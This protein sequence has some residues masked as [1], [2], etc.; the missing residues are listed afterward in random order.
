MREILENRDKQKEQPFLYTSY[1]FFYTQMYI[2]Y[3]K[4]NYSIYFLFIMYLFIFKE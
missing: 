2:F 4:S 1:L 3:K